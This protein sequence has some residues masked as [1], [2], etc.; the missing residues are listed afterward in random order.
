MIQFTLKNNIEQSKINA[1][2]Y[3]LKSW[4][5]DVEVKQFSITLPKKKHETFSLAA[6]MW[7]DY[8]VDAA[9]LRKLAWKVN[10]A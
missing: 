10:K 1:L 8:A 3:F 5:I 4:D 2:F 7:S 9:D 6:G